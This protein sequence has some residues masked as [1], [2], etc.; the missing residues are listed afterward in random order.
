MSQSIK[1]IKNIVLSFSVLLGFWV[2]FG[3]IDNSQA[4]KLNLPNNSTNSVSKKYRFR[5]GFNPPGTSKPRHTVGAATRPG[6]VGLCPQDEIPVEHSLTALLSDTEQAYTLA[7]RPTLLVYIPQTTA[8]QGSLIIKNET[9][10]YYHETVVSLPSQPGIIGIK[11]PNNIPS[12]QSGKYLWSFT[13][14]CGKTKRPSDPYV[15]GEIIKKD[16]N[17]LVEQLQKISLKEQLASYQEKLIWYDAIFSAAKLKTLEPEEQSTWYQLLE[18]V[19]LQQIA[20]QP[21]NQI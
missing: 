10:D 5:N 12:L 11:M 18:S 21:I 4:E 14:I 1:V 8:Q 3:L 2:N 19:G 7:E 20:N 15:M 13:V 6:S 9:E 17:K 16:N